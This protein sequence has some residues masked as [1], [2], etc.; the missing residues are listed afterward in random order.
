MFKPATLRTSLIG[1]TAL[2][3]VALL[4][5]PNQAKAC[6]GSTAINGT[7]NST[8][9]LCAGADVSIQGTVSGAN[10]AV[11]VNHVAA[12]T[13]S[14]S[15]TISGSTTGIRVTATGSLS[16]GIS[17]GGTIEG[18]IGILVSNKSS[19]A[20][21]GVTNSTLGGVVH[22]TGI[23]I[24]VVSS[25]TI[26]GGVHNLGLIDG[27]TGGQGINLFNKSDISGG[28]TNAGTIRGGTVAGGSETAIRLFNT[29]DISGGVHNTGTIQGGPSGFGIRVNTGSDISG[30]IVNAVG[31]TIAGGTAGTRGSA[32][33]VDFGSNISGGIVN[34]GSIHGGGGYTAI[35][36]YHGSDVASVTN[37][38]TI[39]GSGSGPVAGAAFDISTG[40]SISG[41][42]TNSGGL[43]GTWSSL[44]LRTG[45]DIG[46]VGI[47]NQVSGLISATNTAAIW[48]ASG[49]NISGGITN[50][51]TIQGAKQGI[52]IKS[53]TMTGAITNKA[54]GVISGGTTGILVK[55]GGNIAGGISNAGTISG[56][57]TGILTET[58]ADISGGVTNSGH[59]SG[60]L[61]GINVVSA[62]ITGAITNNAGG[63]ISGTTAGLSV[64]GGDIADVITNHGTISGNTAVLIESSGDISG[65]IVNSA[66]GKILGGSEGIYVTGGKAGSADISGGILNSGTISG[67]LGIG[68]RQ[69]D[70]SGGIVNNAGGTISGDWAIDIQSGGD[71]SGGVVNHAGGTIAGVSGGIHLTGGKGGAADISGG[72]DNSGTISG[73]IFGI[74]VFGADISGLVRN[75]VGGV[76]SGGT[77]GI[78]LTGGKFGTT[79]ISGGIQ[80]FG[81]IVGLQGIVVGGSSAISGSITNEP[82]GV[83]HGTG[84]TAIFLQNVSGA[85]PIVV[86]GGS[87]IGSVIDTTAA[88]SNFSPVSINGDFTTAGNWTVSDLAVNGTASLGIRSGDV[89]TTSRMTNPSI[90]TFSF[91]VGNGAAGEL[92]NN[93][94]GVVLTSATLAAHVDGATPALNAPFRIVDGVTAVTGG[95][96]GTLTTL[97]SSSYLWTFKV[98]DGTD[99]ADLG[100]SATD[101][102]DLFLLV[103]Q[104]HTI[105]GSAGNTANATIGNIIESLAGSGD[106][107]ID[108]IANNL[109]NAKTQGE[110]NDIESAAGPTLDDSDVAGAF[111]VDDETLG[112][113]DQHLSFLRT[114][115]GDAMTG[116]AAGNIPHGVSMWGQVF[117]RHADQNDR[118]GV[119]GY[120]SD[121]WGGAV[122][123][124]THNLGDHNVLGLAFSYGHTNANSDNSNDTDTDVDSY[125][126]TVY[127]SHD[128]TQGYYLNG[129]AAYS[130]SNIDRDR[131]NVGGITGLTAH[132]GYDANTWAVAAEGGRDFRRDGMTLTPNLTANW[133]SWDPDS[134]TETGAGGA[135]LM[136]NGDTLNRFELGAGVKAGWDMKGTQGALIKPELRIGYRYALV[137]DKVED[138]AQFTGGG[139]AFKIEGADP[140]R[141]TLDLGATVRLVTTRNWEF[142][143]SYD[144]NWK[145]DYT[146]HAGFLRAAYRF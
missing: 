22:G 78:Y 146:S 40:G 133:M 1:S 41:G 121:T 104:N 108:L 8:V 117:G 2:I 128:F 96:G 123:V 48:L 63:V 145:S 83:I 124:D 98:V 32:I 100:G 74:S 103:S 35:G 73:G 125:Q 3:G 122:G 70:I 97:A 88:A 11:S 86:N 111:S 28:V 68:V 6:T 116:M 102:T 134:Y 31:G 49:G 54:G 109:N 4:V 120:T 18:S 94:G 53:S 105:S 43:L 12:I 34:N 107:Q 60:G 37:T 130:W 115:D 75:L 47:V 95:P 110:V 87:I 33:L 99:A 132:G 24:S 91:G 139:G 44:F 23:G 113:T 136:V 90:G 27:G 42:I 84:G 56:G 85:T 101:N 141:S 89:F 16:G 140:A 80:N 15:G 7:V 10:P 144:F 59:I 127:G 25:G 119:A 64:R 92:V 21:A 118:D 72:V 5:V 30:G 69:A 55:V 66:G 14:N 51:G 9:D 20:G 135:N 29:S 138:T 131:H 36:I 82:G 46:G 129:E 57:K 137:N 62:T 106:P 65:G 58:N 39:Q 81:T 143:G 45:G 142:T 126:L 52:H 79:D 76:I 114:G 50:S 61:V 93:V 112:L 17:N 77:A 13:V 38:G 19:L 26:S 67:D 71:I